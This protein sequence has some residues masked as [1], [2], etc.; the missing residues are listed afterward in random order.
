LY[1][2]TLIEERDPKNLH[3][4]IKVIPPS[5]SIFREEE[6]DY[7]GQGSGI[8]E[9]GGISSS[10]GRCDFGKIRGRGEVRELE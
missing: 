8:G 4:L 6:E 9:D 1:H 2:A 10:R 3:I 5:D 7:N